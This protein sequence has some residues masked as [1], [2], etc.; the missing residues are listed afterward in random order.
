MNRDR[1]FIIDGHSMIYRA[2]FKKGPPL[3]SPTGEPTRGTFFF[4]KMLMSLVDHHKPEFMAVASDPP[5]GSTFRREMFPP[6]KAKRDDQEPD[7]SVLIQVRRIK[8]VIDLLGLPVIEVWP[9]EADD[10][11]ASL[12]D[13][14]ASP[15]VEC[16]IVSRDKDLHQ[17]IGPNCSMFDAQGDEWVREKDVLERWKVPPDQVV[18][19]QTLQGDTTDNVPGVKGIGPKKA[20]DLILE[21]GSVEGVLENASS[22]TPALRKN[23]E[24]ADLTMCRALVELRKDVP[25][26]IDAD[27]LA[28]DGFD[29]RAARPLF[30]H[31]GFTE[32]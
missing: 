27:M 12:V 23:L 22:L 28:F 18:E 3:T 9:Y 20:T 14:C 21:Y 1:F 32:W 29:M 31:L 26:P 7:E 24:S 2:V 6:Y 15:D 4:V 5:R 11:I 8:E 13:V 25:L 30:R 17:L 10:V 19:I 16:V